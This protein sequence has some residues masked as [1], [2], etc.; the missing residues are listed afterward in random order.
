MPKFILNIK[1]FE[2]Y[3]GYINDVAWVDHKSFIVTTRE[4]NA[5]ILFD[6]NGKVIDLLRLSSFRPTRFISNRLPGT[7]IK[8]IDAFQNRVLELEN[9][10]Q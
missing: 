6:L 8:L 4:G 3:N 7:P 10:N 9:I 2:K 5:L 1:G